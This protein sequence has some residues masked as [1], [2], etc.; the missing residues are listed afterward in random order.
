M[1]DQLRSDIQERLRQLLA[2]ADKLRGAL[3]ALGGGNASAPAS[4]AA[5]PKRSATRSRDAPQAKSR[6]SRADRRTSGAAAT[7]ERS[8]APWPSSW[9]SRRRPAG[10]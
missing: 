5:S 4:P 6:K 1:I 7:V 2:E 3:A 9:R 10:Q 8:P